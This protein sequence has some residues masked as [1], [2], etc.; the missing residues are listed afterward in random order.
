MGT[1]L[2]NGTMALATD[3]SG[4]LTGL[5]ALAVVIGGIILITGVGTRGMQE[6]AHRWI[7][8][9]VLGTIF[10]GSFHTIA[11]KITGSFR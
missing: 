8:Q 10:V 11:D 4:A 6:F 3:L 2:N 9:G 1:A 7:W 5:L